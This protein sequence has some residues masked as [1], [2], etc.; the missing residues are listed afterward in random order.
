[1]R[2]KFAGEGLMTYQGDNLFAV[3]LFAANA[4]DQGTTKVDGSDHCMCDPD[5]KGSQSVNLGK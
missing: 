3:K 5:C 4:R 2:A 1:M